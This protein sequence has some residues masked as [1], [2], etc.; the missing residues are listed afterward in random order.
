MPLSRDGPAAVR[1]S[2][3]SH[4]PPEI[5]GR[6]A[7]ARVARASQSGCPMLAT[8][9]SATLIGLDAHAVRVEVE[10][11]RGPPFFELVGLAEVA[12]RESRVR[13]KSALAQLGV[14]INDCRIVVNLAPADVRK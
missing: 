7:G 4:D 12:V 1:A 10:A 2:H 6:S 14:D 9:H 8:A 5:P 13:V 11:T 3:G